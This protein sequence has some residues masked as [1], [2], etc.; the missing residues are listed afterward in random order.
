MLPK[1]GYT[2]LI[3][4]NMLLIYYDTSH[5]IYFSAKTHG[6]AYIY[7][8]VHSLAHIQDYVYTYL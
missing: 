6:E 3:N 1:Y 5:H 2:I 4:C 8:I 7:H